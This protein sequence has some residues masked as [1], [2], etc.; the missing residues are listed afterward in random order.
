MAFSLQRKILKS[1]DL[2][3]QVRINDIIISCHLFSS[4]K[5]NNNDN[6]NPN[7]FPCWRNASILFLQQA[8][9][10]AIK[11]VLDME[12]AERQWSWRVG[13][14]LWKHQRPSRKGELGKSWS[15]CRIVVG[16]DCWLKFW[17][18]LKCTFLPLGQISEDF[19]SFYRSLAFYELTLRTP[20]SLSWLT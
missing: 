1:S 12:T 7:S 5:N 15:P 20:G 17:W 11:S 18:G 2:Q 16:R 8:I 14:K 3:E 4:E 10:F 13:E 9:F 19:L 6:K